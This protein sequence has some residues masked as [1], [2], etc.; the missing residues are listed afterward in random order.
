MSGDSVDIRITRL[1]DAASVLGQLQRGRGEG[2]L[3]AL[4]MP[5]A[6]AADLVWEC[7]VH[8]P[9]YDLQIDSRDLYYATL[10]QQVGVRVERLRPQNCPTPAPDLDQRLVIGV[11]A[12]LVAVGA[13]GADA[14]LL[15][16]VAHG[17]DWDD[18]IYEISQSPGD[19]YRQLPAVLDA[20]F[21]ED[22]CVAIVHRWRYE[23]PWDQIANVRRW[24]KRAI[25]SFDDGPT[26]N[27]SPEPPPMDR[28]AAELL[29][30]PWSRT[31]PKRLLHRLT[32]ML[33]AGE[34]DELIA[35]LETPGPGRW[36]A[37]QALARL[38]DPGGM[39]VAEAIVRVDASGPERA[40]ALRYL[41]NLSGEHTLTLAR[42]W[43]GE[44]GGRGVAARGVFERHAEASDL[45]LLVGGLAEA[46]EARDFYA[47]C[48]FIDALA[49]LSDPASAEQIA[50]IYE[51]AEYSYAR[52]RA[53][54]ALVAIDEQAFIDRYARSALW[55]CEREIQDLAIGL[56]GNHVD[57]VA[58]RQIE[59][60][61][62]Q[63][64]R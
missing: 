5:P 61:E 57:E 50:A 7:I 26:A 31:L 21:P 55:D 38:D 24:V 35:A 40:A 53:A 13:N 42:S 33:R 39:S 36:V 14:A 25:D 52:R 9:R 16:H 22:E 2:F 44:S 4:E 32:V 29:L 8:D 58:A 45:L 20:R 59:A 18:A 17:A 46:W 47:L 28:P 34:R 41:K 15:G 23:V 60:I 12:E 43:V 49:R 62:G 48:S 27:E 11:L 51:E 64:I 6:Q 37:F 56:L 19:L 10:A 30:Y 54:R 3:A 63:R 1:A